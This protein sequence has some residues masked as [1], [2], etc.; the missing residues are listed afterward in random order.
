MRSRTIAGADEEPFSVQ[1]LG[2]PSD[3][4]RFVPCPPARVGVVLWRRR[5]DIGD[6]MHVSTP[7]ALL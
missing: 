5:L 7:S 1:L 3:R 6:P 4:I 2:R